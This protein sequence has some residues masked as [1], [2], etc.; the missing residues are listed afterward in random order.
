[1]QKIN[2]T[3]SGKNNAYQ[4]LNAAGIKAGLKEVDNWL[5]NPQ[6]D[7]KSDWIFRVKVNP[8]ELSLKGERRKIETIDFFVN[9]NAGIEF[10]LK[11][12]LKDNSNFELQWN[13]EQVG[14]GI[15]FSENRPNNLVV[16]SNYLYFDNLD[17]SQNEQDLEINWENITSTDEGLIFSLT[18]PQSIS[19]NNHN[20]TYDKVFWSSPFAPKDYDFIKQ[21]LTERKVDKKPFII[22]TILSFDAWLSVKDNGN[23]YIL[24]KK[25]QGKD[26]DLTNDLTYEVPFMESN[27]S[28]WLKLPYR[29][30]E[31][32][33]KRYWDG[34]EEVENMKS[35]IET[36]IQALENGKN[37]NENGSRKP[38]KPA[39]SSDKVSWKVIIPI[40]LFFLIVVVI[41]AT[42]LFKKEKKKKNNF[43]CK[44]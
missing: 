30:R 38:A 37:Q 39:N 33:I 35:E 36:A 2:F 41:G 40:S 16:F 26:T 42:I 8:F 29:Q 27:I 24:G 14:E 13:E 28:G 11:N 32:F 20:F 44:V 17:S 15:G 18:S 22:K 12:A 9:A 10:F 21:R 1:M 6:T 5:A 43:Q 3:K 23:L 19:L 25:G 7:H 31:R 4:K 34:G